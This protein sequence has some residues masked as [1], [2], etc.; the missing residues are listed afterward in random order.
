MLAE[1]SGSG[2]SRAGQLLV[3]RPRRASA[4]PFGQSP[5]HHRAGARHARRSDNMIR[6]R[7]PLRPSTFEP[8]PHGRA[9]MVGD[10]AVGFDFGTSNS[11]IAV[12]EPGQGGEAWLLHLDRGNPEST[13]I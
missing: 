12:V 2:P 3:L 13:L 7:T 11:A 10:V 1:Y 6:S 5:A 8:R 9:G 4:C